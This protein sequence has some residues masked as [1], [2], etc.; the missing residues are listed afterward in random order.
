MDECLTEYFQW[1]TYINSF[2]RTIVDGGDK[3][4]LLAYQLEYFDG[5]QLVI[6]GGSDDVAFKDIEMFSER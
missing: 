5:R 4:F 6:S 1:I 2:K 3:A